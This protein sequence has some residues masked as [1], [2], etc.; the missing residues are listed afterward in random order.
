LE[1]KK[2]FGGFDGIA[3][4]PCYHKECDTIENINP[5]ILLEMGRAAL[6]TIY[7]LSTIIDLKTF[8]SK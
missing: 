2:L 5:Y 1:E 4:D 6:D 3:L 8:L 7:Y